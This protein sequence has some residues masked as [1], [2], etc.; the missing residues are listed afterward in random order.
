MQENETKFFNALAKLQESVSK[1]TKNTENPYFKSKYTD[2]NAIFEEVKPKIKE[3]G[4]VLIQTVSNGQLL[5]D[6]VHIETG[7]KLHSCMDLLTAKPDMQQLGSAI[8]YARRY[9]ILP[10][11]N[12]E[13]ADDDGNGASG[14]TKT[15]DELDTYEDFDLAIKSCVSEKQVS[16]LW[17]KWRDK[18]AENSEEYKKLQKTSG[19]MKTKLANPDMNVKVR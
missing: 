9:S 3:Q 12:I 14:K 2:L 6:L 8:T 15:F 1:L 7:Q 5:T 4:F 19:D 17:Y 16:A 18:F 11:L 10:M 13:C